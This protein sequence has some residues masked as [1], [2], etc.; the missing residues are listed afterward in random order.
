MGMLMLQKLPHG[1]KVTRGLQTAACRSSTEVSTLTDC[2]DTAT[3]PVVSASDEYLTSSLT[4]QCRDSC[5]RGFGTSGSQRCLP[6]FF[7]KLC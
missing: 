1:H 3:F 5:N 4:A 2:T 6:A 7:R